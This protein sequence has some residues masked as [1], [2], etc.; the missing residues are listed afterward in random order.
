MLP[1]AKT[2]SLGRKIRDFYCYTDFYFNRGYGMLGSPMNFLRIIFYTGGSLFFL[3]GALKRF[4]IFIPPDYL[5]V[6]GIPIIL[7][8]IFMGILD[9]KFLKT[10]QKTN[11]I[12]TRYNPIFLRMDKQIRKM[13]GKQEGDITKTRK[14]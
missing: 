13:Y 5:I 9:V 8:L 2:K 12:S 6:F 7:V 3:E 11:E 4:N 1:E 14:T 10:L